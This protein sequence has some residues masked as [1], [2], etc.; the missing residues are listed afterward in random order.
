MN[1]CQ[2]RDDEFPADDG[3]IVS[4]W[5]HKLEGET[6]EFGN[7]SWK[8]AIS[9]MKD[10]SSGKLMLFRQG[11]MPNDIVQGS[12]NNYYFTSVLSILSEKP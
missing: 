7:V 6:P 11:A 1:N 9:F 12:L 4:N 3:S 5:D 10:D 2:F 8:R